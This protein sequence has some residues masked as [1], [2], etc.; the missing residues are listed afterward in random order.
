MTGRDLPTNKATLS[1]M[2]EGGRAGAKIRFSD[3]GEDET[4]PGYD[5]TW[6]K[7]EMHFWTFFLDEHQL[8]PGRNW[9]HS[10]PSRPCQVG[11]CNNMIML[12]FTPQHVRARDSMFD[13]DET[14]R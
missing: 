6:R 5:S 3:V 8:H 12:F 2:I 7:V 11:F 4:R 13:V 14:M 10:R 9:L 1:K